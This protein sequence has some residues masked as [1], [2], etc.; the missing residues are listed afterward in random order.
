MYEKYDAFI[1]GKGGG[2]GE[3]TPQVGSFTTSNKKVFIS[4]RLGRICMEQRCGS[5]LNQ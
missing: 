5:H 4:F 3:Y 2:G 1:P